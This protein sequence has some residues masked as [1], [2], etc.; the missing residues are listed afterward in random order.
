MATR[1]RTDGS[2]HAAPASLT[3]D[4]LDDAMAPGLTDRLCTQCGL[5]CDGTLFGDV[6]LRGR[7]EVTRLLALGL[8]VDEGD[9]DADVLPLPCAALRGS[10]CGVY[11]HRPS[12]C[13]QFEC[14]LLQR[15]RRGEVSVARAAA[16]VVSARAQAD[17]VRALLAE[18]EPR[19]RRLPLR[20]RC[21]DALT[22]RRTHALGLG[23][24]LGAAM[25]R[26]ERTIARTFL[27]R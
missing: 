4:N 1:P 21:A 18:V 9:G 24:A 20:E 7:P 17:A 11:A 2:P 6:E 5:C 13:R 10:C 23:P 8:A 12:T 16:R 14:G 26:L 25:A 19:P 22:S 15:V 3:A 27:G